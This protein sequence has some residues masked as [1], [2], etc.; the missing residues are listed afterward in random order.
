MKWYRRAADQGRSDAQY[1][2]G[3]LLYQQN[4]FAEA[5]KWIRLSR[6]GLK[7][8]KQSGLR[9]PTSR[10]NPA[11]DADQREQVNNAPWIGEGGANDAR[12][13]SRWPGNRPVG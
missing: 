4:N 2:L 6:P 10:R 11:D 8:V 7:S 12:L 13:L 3:H 9:G 5:V 1:Q